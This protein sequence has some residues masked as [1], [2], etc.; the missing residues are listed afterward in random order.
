MLNKLKNVNKINFEENNTTA[1]RELEKSH[2]FCY[3]LNTFT[4]NFYVRCIAPFPIIWH[5][6]VFKQKTFVTKNRQR[7]QRTKPTNQR[8]DIKK[9]FKTTDLS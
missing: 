8:T 6:S 2:T 1:T 9:V 4:D 7:Y 3:T 5:T